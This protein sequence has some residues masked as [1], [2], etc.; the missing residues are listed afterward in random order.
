MENA[1]SK[2]IAAAQRRRGHCY[3]EDQELSNIW[4]PA[5]AVSP[6]NQRNQTSHI[7]Y[8]DTISKDT[9]L[10]LQEAATGA[11]G[12]TWHW[13]SR[14]PPHYC[15]SWGITYFWGPL[16]VK[17]RDYCEESPIDEQQL[18]KYSDEQ[19]CHV[20]P[21]SDASFEL[22]HIHGCIEWPLRDWPVSYFDEGAIEHYPCKVTVECIYNLLTRDP[23]KSTDSTHRHFFELTWRRF[24]HN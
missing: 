23:N 3:W 20:L 5:G 19:Q 1:A 15:H 2:R 24:I 21:H 16:S 13:G 7:L 18:V 8:T 6:V 12:I 14:E 10:V 17:H 4:Y 22:H 11:D 9:A